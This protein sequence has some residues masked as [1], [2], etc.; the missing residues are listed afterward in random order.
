MNTLFCNKDFIAHSTESKV[1]LIDL[2]KYANYA[3][4]N[5][6]S[7]NTNISEELKQFSKKME[8]YQL[9]SMIYME[10]SQLMEYIQ[11]IK[12][13]FEKSQ[14]ELIQKYNKMTQ[15][16]TILSSDLDYYYDELLNIKRIL[17]NKDFTTEINYIRKKMSSKISLTDEEKIKM[18]FFI[19][20]NSQKTFLEKFK[21]GNGSNYINL[22]AQEKDYKE[23]VRKISTDIESNLN[24]NNTLTTKQTMDLK[25][26]ME[27]WT[28]A[29][30]KN[31]LEELNNTYNK[32]IQNND[33]YLK[34]K[35]INSLMKFLN[36]NRREAEILSKD[37]TFKKRLFKNVEQKTIRE[38]ISILK[39]ELNEYKIIED[40]FNTY[41]KKY[42]VCP[43]CSFKNNLI[44]MTDFH[45]QDVHKKA[46]QKN[47]VRPVEVF[48]PLFNGNGFTSIYNP[49]VYTNELEYIYDIKK[50]YLNVE[51]DF[52]KEI[53]E[54]KIDERIMGHL[55]NR[56]GSLKHTVVRNIQKTK[57]I[58]DKTSL[59][60]E[61]LINKVKYY[62]DM[63][64]IDN[65]LFN[66]LKNIIEEELKNTNNLK[67][68][69]L[70]RLVKEKIFTTMLNEQKYMI[71]NEKSP[72]TNVS[73]FLENIYDNQTRKVIKN[74]KLFNKVLSHNNTQEL[75]IFLDKILK[76]TVSLMKVNELKSD[77]KQ[78]FVNS[79]KSTF[80]R[81]NVINKKG[82][83]KV[84]NIETTL[85]AGEVNFFKLF[86]L[87]NYLS[88]EHEL[89]EEIKEAIVKKF[90]K[91]GEKTE[92]SSLIDLIN[93]NNEILDFVEEQLMSV[94][95]IEMINDMLY[96]EDDEDY[97]LTEEIYEF[98]KIGSN[99]DSKIYNKYLS[100]YAILVKYVKENISSGTKTNYNALLLNI[101][102]NI[103]QDI[104]DKSNVK[105]TKKFFENVIKSME[106]V[107]NKDIELVEEKEQ[108]KPKQQVVERQTVSN[109]D[110]LLNDFMNNDEEE[111]VEEV[112]EQQIEE[113]IVEEDEEVIDYDDEEEMVEYDM[114]QQELLDELF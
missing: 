29:N 81:I 78:I 46:D 99:I 41:T 10:E 98:L 32:N 60:K 73:L 70:T 6:R 58:L 55:T 88:E 1:G 5:K 37:K 8:K 114:E 14:K 54:G 106:I 47:K 66:K 68:K 28:D 102:F 3:L 82:I 26:V 109:K 100:D 105:R 18:S 51:V 85:E 103:L 30:T 45:I 79:Y 36:I 50:N 56:D 113:E 96:D 94:E 84:K 9:S 75:M 101:F 17:R 59:V 42:T 12:T 57:Q 89:F 48:V 108:V 27:I 31:I 61:M 23:I 35:L 65:D 111:I 22:N 95:S 20:L 53:V 92:E 71:Y 39:S 90:Y 80:N 83:N 110:D 43:H 2:F 38:K 112:I 21:I 4:Y 62:K 11:N 24:I 77:A 93:N 72:L 33:L 104:L 16:L 86:V 91:D 44:L 74:E 40:F 87:I 49:K 25:N 13:T 107:L 15:V 64:V 52:V 97:Q 69:D 34:S 67:V 76:G 19:N 63:K 7:N